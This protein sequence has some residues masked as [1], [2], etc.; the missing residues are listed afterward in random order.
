MADTTVTFKNGAASVPPP[1]ATGAAAESAA[2]SAPLNAGNVIDVFQLCQ[3]PSVLSED[4]EAY[5]KRI[6]AAVQ[7]SGR[8]VEAKRIVGANYEARVLSYANQLVGFVFGETYV[9]GVDGLPKA[10]CITDFRNSLAAAGLDQ[11]TLVQF[12][13][14]EKEDY[15]KVD[16]MAAYV[17]NLFMA[18]DRKEIRDLS[19]SQFSGPNFRITTDIATVRNFVESVWPLAT[20]PRCD[21]GFLLYALR[22]IDKA[23]EK[24]GRQ[25]MQQIPMVAVTGY[26]DFTYAA[27]NSMYA[28]QMKYAPTFVCTG[29]HSKI[30]SPK[31]SAIGM[32]LASYLFIRQ[33]RWLDQFSTFTKGSPDIGN[34]L[35]DDKGHLVHVASINDRNRV[36][37][38]Y[39]S[40]KLP[41]FALDLQLGAPVVPGL[42]DMY[43]DVGR[44]NLAI[45]QFTGGKGAQNSQNPRQ[46][47]PR[48]FD[49]RVRI[50]KNGKADFV[51]TRSVDYL[52]LVQNGISPQDASE[53]LQ[54]TMEPKSKADALKRFYPDVQFEYVTD[55]V[56]LNPNWI[57]AVAAD[58]GQTLKVQIEGGFN[59]ST[60]DIMSLTAFQPMGVGMMPSFLMPTN[61]S[62]YATGFYGF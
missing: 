14:V 41:F 3:S 7:A 2:A 10:A 42:I 19:A 32:A 22:P 17:T 27:G 24:D 33:G 11:N 9:A 39:L 46:A 60:Y 34:L 52:E 4:G 28:P 54:F 38:N 12:I 26:T 29:I 5:I 58:L 43:S 40:T 44:F 8:Q 62:Y 37:D 59:Q 6:E 50:A 35:T 13:V 15:A 61:T 57:D 25:Q 20:M 30:V 48:R 47:T 23:F 55:R 45:D 1:S 53:F 16:L 56:I 36:L 49:G 51:D 21:V 18:S 31:I